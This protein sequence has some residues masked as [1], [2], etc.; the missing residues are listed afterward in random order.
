MTQ[1]DPVLPD[2]K[3]AERIFGLHSSSQVSR[4]S[5][6]PTGLCHHV[7]E[8]TTAD[9]RAF[10]VRIATPETRRELEGGCYWHPVLKQLGIPV[11]A[12]HASGSDGLFGYM[13]MDRL[14]GADL[15]QVYTRLSASEKQSI[16]ENV[17]GMQQKVGRLPRARGYGFAVSHE[18]ANTEGQ[19]SWADVVEAEVARSEERINRVGLIN[20]RYVERVRCYLAKFEATLHAV[21]PTPFLDDTTT[22][23][24]IISD[25]ALS[26]IVDTDQVCFGDPLFTV[27]LTHM[28]LLSLGTDTDYIDYWLEAIEATT[29]QRAIMHAYTLVFC[30][31]FMSELGQVFNKQVA[32]SEERAAR[33]A[34]IFES[35]VNS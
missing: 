15:G 18:Q 33:L 34:T 6:F 13:L 10:A 30:L 29:E 28:A 27:G 12:L 7:Y 35:L 11:P 2:E 1:D 5:R 4:V 16:A 9:D 21:P 3:T 22:K 32:F 19:N 25:G 8:I 23:N 20:G 26:G 14:P 31:G 17:A 24:V